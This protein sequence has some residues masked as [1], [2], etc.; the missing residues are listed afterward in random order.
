MENVGIRKYF[1]GKIN[2]G[3]GSKS[4]DFESYPKQTLY[5]TLTLA[6]GLGLG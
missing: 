5:L 3:L 1:K 4:F 2:N 6:L